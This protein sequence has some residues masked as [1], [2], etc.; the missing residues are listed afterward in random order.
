MSQNLLRKYHLFKWSLTPLDV[1]GKFHFHWIQLV[2]GDEIAYKLVHKYEI[3]VRIWSRNSRLTKTYCCHSQYYKQDW[4]EISSDSSWSCVQCS[5]IL[6]VIMNKLI[7]V[8]IG[9]ALLLIVCTLVVLLAIFSTFE[10][11][12][13]SHQ[14]VTTTKPHVIL[15]LADD[16]G[17]YYLN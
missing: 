16:L 15:I 14:H 2:T 17:K 13:K 7:I 6:N 5:R 4:V 3:T 8:V 11:Q 12:D 9:S 1:G 10:H